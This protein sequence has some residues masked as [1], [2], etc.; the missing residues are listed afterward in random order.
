MDRTF[1]SLKHP[2]ARRNAA[3]ACMNA[4]EGWSVLVSPPTKSRDQEA[5]YHSLFGEV[6][7]TREFMG[8][9]H[10]AETWKRLLVDAFARVKAADSDPLPGY[11]LMVPSLDRTGYVQLGIQTR[12]FSKQ[13]ASEF[14]EFLHAWMAVG[15]VAA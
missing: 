6:A 9:K 4:P 15:E 13:H 7:K 3:Y 14:I 10:D 12:S 8:V 11:G 5:L 2:Q 1:F